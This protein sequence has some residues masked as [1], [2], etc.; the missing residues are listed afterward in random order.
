[1]TLEEREELEHIGGEKI[2]DVVRDG[3]EWYITYLKANE[4]SAVNSIQTL[5]NALDEI[6]LDVGDL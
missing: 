6:P 5:E 1:M 2:F 4:P 3:L